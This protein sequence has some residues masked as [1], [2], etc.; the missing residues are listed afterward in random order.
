MKRR[1]A[2]LSFTLFAFA[3]PTFARVLSYSPYS[4]RTSLAGFHDRS[5]RHFV[6]I[7]SVDDSNLWRQH[8]L[9]LYDST[10]SQ[11]PRVVYPA[12][13]GTAS[14]EAAALYEPKTTAGPLTVP[15]LLVS[16]SAPGRKLA[17]ALQS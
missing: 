8:Q 1:L 13:G 4:N 2:V 16:R 9:V 10:G 7:E 15:M 6:L 5:S 17:H 3:V 14:I 12:N 11:E